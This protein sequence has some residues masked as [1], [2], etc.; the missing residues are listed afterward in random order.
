MSWKPPGAEH[1]RLH[2]TGEGQDRRTID[3]GVPEPGQQVG[4][5]RT[6]NPKTRSRFARQL[7]IRRAR[8]RSCP[9]V[10]HTE[11]AELAVLLLA[12]KGIS[13]TEIR[14]T[15]DS[16]HGV[17][18]PVDHRFGH[19]IADRTDGRCRLVDPDV[20][21]IVADFTGVGVDVIDVPVDRFA[22]ERIEVPP[23]PWASEAPVLDRSFTQRATLVWALVA[24]CGVLAIDSGDRDLMMR[25]GAELHHTSLGHDVDV[26]DPV[27]GE[28]RFVVVRARRLRCTVLGILE[29]DGPV[30]TVAERLVLR[31][32]TP[33][34]REVLT[35]RALPPLLGLEVDSA[36][37]VVRAIL[38]DG[39]RGRSILITVFL[40]AEAVTERARR[41]LL[42]RLD[43]PIRS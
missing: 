17:D 33:A 2:L 5:A 36:H 32:S 42:D 13:E 43:D 23:V 39:D 9:L 4:R 8:E 29:V 34:Q 1:L 31:S 20:E 40:T 25:S 35:G 21:A 3:L 12:A 26:A 27:P 24:E 10:P 37:D 38:R 7:G 28:L 6:G 15:D 41:T 30:R 14:A 11:V 18:T 19:H 22:G 16:E